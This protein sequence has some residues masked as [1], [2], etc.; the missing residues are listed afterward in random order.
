MLGEN[1]CWDLYIK[2]KSVIKQI[3]K[4]KIAKFK[5]VRQT[6]TEKEKSLFPV[7]SNRPITSTRPNH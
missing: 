1:I 5:S 7:L 4:K 2:I 6:G 3:T